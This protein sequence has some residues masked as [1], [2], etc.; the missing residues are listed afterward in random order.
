MAKFTLPRFMSSFSI[1]AKLNEVVEALE[2]LMQNRIL[3]RDNISGEPNQ[4]KTILDMDNNPI[5]NLPDAVN[6]RDAV[7]FKQLESVVKGIADGAGFVFDTP[8]KAARAPL[9]VGAKYSTKGANAVGDGGHGDF[10]VEAASG[11]PDGYG[12]VLLA[13]GNHGVL[14]KPWNALQFGARADNTA[15]DTPLMQLA[16]NGYQGFLSTPKQTNTSR[17]RFETALTLGGLDGIGGSKHLEVNARLAAPINMSASF[18]EIKN[19]RLDQ[20][21]DAEYAININGT[22]PDYFGN[23]VHGVK[24]TGLKGINNPGL[25]T[26]IS[27]VYG[28]GSGPTV[29]DGIGVN[30]TEFDTSMSFCILEQYRRGIITNKGLQ[31]VDL[32]LVKCGRAL[33]L[34]SNGQPMQLLNTYLDTPSEVGAAFNTMNGAQL[35]NTQVLKVGQDGADPLTSFGFTFDATSSNNSLVNVTFSQP[36]GAV[37]AGGFNFAA[38]SINNLLVGVSGAYKLNSNNVERIRNQTVFGAMGGWARHNNVPRNC[39]ARAVSVPAGA[40]VD[41]VFILDWDYPVASNNFFLFTGKWASR[42]VTN[43]AAYG[44]ADIVVSNASIGISSLLTKQSGSAA[45]SWAVNTV[46]LSGSTLTVTIENT[47]SVAGSISMELRRSIDP[48]GLSF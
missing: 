47:G 35:V 1:T 44:A 43:D 46:V 19:I 4:M 26:K 33:T 29:A 24:L 42:G 21:N 20:E 48:G 6:P 15:N 34:N 11:T 10:I 7:N 38:G 8:A 41:L 25:E 27:Y 18:S 40:T 30:I 5:I 36:D 31:G 37:W 23:H 13:N 39:R 12:R 32:H 17:Y 45:V 28:V 3:Y 22:A 14:Q 16:L 9:P 2:N